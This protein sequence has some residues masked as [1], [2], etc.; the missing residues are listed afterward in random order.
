MTPLRC[1]LLAFACIALLGASAR[2]RGQVPGQPN[3]PLAVVF[4]PSAAA[5]AQADIR[6]AIGVELGAPVLEAPAEGANTLTISVVANGRILLRYWPQA[7]VI[8]R[9]LP[10]QRDRTATALDIAM[11]AQNLVR[12]QASGLLAAAPPASEAGT[13]TPE[14]PYP[15]LLA[16]RDLTPAPAPAQSWLDGSLQ[17]HLFAQFATGGDVQVSPQMPRVDTYNSV[18]G[19]ARLEVTLLRYLAAGVGVA[20]SHWEGA[21]D[22]S[23]TLRVSPTEFSDVQLWLRPRLPLGAFE[24]YVAL[25]IGAS[26]MADLEVPYNEEPPDI[27]SNFAA[28]VGTIWWFYGRTGLLVELGISYHHAGIFDFSLDL[29]QPAGSLGVAFAF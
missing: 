8:E 17:L 5:L 19:S 20:Y 22:A 11:L 4:E 13:P 15:R 6:A 23:G 7:H 26:L 3:P 28:N 18:G 10:A 12:D 16:A 21:H 25:C 29:L 14:Y 1:A 24:L 9:S 27:G 2:A